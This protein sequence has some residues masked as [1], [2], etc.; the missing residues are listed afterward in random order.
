MSTPLPAVVAAP[1]SEPAPEID[2]A[3]L[4]GQRTA[5]GAHCDRLLVL[6]NAAN[7]QRRTDLHG[8]NGGAG[9]SDAHRDR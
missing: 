9:F 7:R 1:P 6:A 8:T 4:V 3:T 2:L 5:V